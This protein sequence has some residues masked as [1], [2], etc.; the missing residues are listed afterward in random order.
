MTTLQDTHPEFQELLESFGGQISW[1]KHPQALINKIQEQYF[2]WCFFSEYVGP[3]D[4]FDLA[5]EARK[6]AFS[7]LLG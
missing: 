1:F 6:C 7:C 4:G 3:W 2:H 5:Q